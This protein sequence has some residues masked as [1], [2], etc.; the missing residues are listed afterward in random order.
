MKKK[1]VVC[2]F[3]ILGY[4][5]IIKQDNYELASNVIENIL[6]K[7]PTKALESTKQLFNNKN[8]AL[9]DAAISSIQKSKPIIVSDSILYVL[10]LTGKKTDQFKLLVF[11]IYMAHFIRMNFESGLPLR[12][13]ID[14][15]EVY[16][17]KNSFAGSSI[18]DTY[19]LSS[20]MEYS[21]CI[22]TDRFMEMF[23]HVLFP[24]LESAASG[25]HV[26]I[27]SPFKDGNKLMY[28]LNW[29]N[30][31][32]KFGNFDKEVRQYIFDSFFEHN[33]DVSDKEIEKINNTEKLIR[34][35]LHLFNKKQKS[36]AQ[37]LALDKSKEN[38]PNQAEAPA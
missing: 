2:F 32:P 1:G 22:L 16:I 27:L 28:N 3:D 10:P 34:Y 30:P 29:V 14:F 9:L 12:G 8:I 33:K 38:T 17:H 13:A 18:V 15:G 4:Q 19:T 35:C 21:G 36:K 6:Y 23:N 24:E 26:K 25:F 37:P 31:F 11:I 20:K 5:N 7:V